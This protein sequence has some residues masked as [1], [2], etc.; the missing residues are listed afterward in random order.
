MK[1]E[2]L[3]NVKLN[4]ET[5]ADIYE[6]YLNP[7]IDYIDSIDINDDGSID[8]Y[9]S[10]DGEGAKASYISGKRFLETVEKYGRFDD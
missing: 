5:I 9:Y 8:I 2:D 7:G 3:E 4:E 10:F 1:R 6:S